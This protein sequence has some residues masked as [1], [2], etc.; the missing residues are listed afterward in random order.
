MGGVSTAGTPDSYYEGVGR[1]LWVEWKWT[2]SYRPLL[3][4]EPTPLQQHWLRRA[5][6]NGVRVAVICGCPTRGFVFP[7]LTWESRETIAAVYEAQTKKQIADWI[8]K[9]VL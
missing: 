8:S 3:I 6:N 9:V 2:N 4:P 7:G 5:Y 1:T